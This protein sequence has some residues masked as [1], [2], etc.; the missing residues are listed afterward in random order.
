M[1]MMLVGTGI[2]LEL[3]YRNVSSSR[4]NGKR[5]GSVGASLV[6]GAGADGVTIDVAIVIAIVCATVD[7][8]GMVLAR[9]K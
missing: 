9:S 6:G 8:T 5:C 2:Q 4:Q 7:K 1:G 3:E